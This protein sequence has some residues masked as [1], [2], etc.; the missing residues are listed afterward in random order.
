[1]FPSHFGVLLLVMATIGIAQTRIT[2]VA[3]LVKHQVTSSLQTRVARNGSIY[4][5]NNS[6]NNSASQSSFEDIENGNALPVNISSLKSVVQ[7]W[8][9]VCQELCGAGLGGA[10]CAFHCQSSDTPSFLPEFSDKKPEICKDLCGLQLGDVS[11]S[12]ESDEVVSNNCTQKNISDHSRNLVCNIFCEHSNTTLS[13]CSVCR[14]GIEFEMHNLAENKV[15]TTTPDW[16]ELCK[17]LCATGDGGSLC[18]C[19]LIPFGRAKPLA[20]TK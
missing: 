17:V 20:K 5:D 6:N 7:D 11:C 12:C 18:R 1:M 8:S 2:P 3:N 16:N 15:P 10:P 14:N 19:N 13:G 9:S 4:K